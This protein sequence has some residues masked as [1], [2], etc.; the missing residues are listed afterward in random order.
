MNCDNAFKFAISNDLC[1]IRFSFVIKPSTISSDGNKEGEK[2]LNRNHSYFILVEENPQ[3]GESSNSEEENVNE[4]KHA[5][6]TRNFRTQLEKAMTIASKFISNT[7]IKR[8][9]RL[10][11]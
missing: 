4:S 5:K 6:A 8:V 7:V 9:G 2:M 1:N 10:I 3:A 11:I